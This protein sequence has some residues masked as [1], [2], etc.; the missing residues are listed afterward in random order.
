MVRFFTKLIVL[1]A[2]ERPGKEGQREQPHHWPRAC[3][4]KE[5]LIE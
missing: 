5:I 3:G 4:H 1:P 2:M